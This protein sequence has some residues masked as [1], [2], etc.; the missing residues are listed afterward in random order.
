M[1]TFMSN[2]EGLS[3]SNRKMV[4]VAACIATTP[5]NIQEAV[6]NGSENNEKQNLK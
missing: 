5:T 4:N 2:P 3:H 6:S 1:L